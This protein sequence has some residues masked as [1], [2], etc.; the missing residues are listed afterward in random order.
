MAGDRIFHMHEGSTYIEK[1]VNYV[2][3]NLVMGTTMETTEEYPRPSTDLRECIDEVLPLM[4]N[5]SHWFCIYRGMVDHGLNKKKDYSGFVALIENLYPEGVP[6]GINAGDISKLDINSFAKPVKEW[7]G[8]DA[9]RKG[10]TFVQYKKIAE[11]FE[12]LM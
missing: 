4:S 12:S 2:K 10:V 11:M 3:G 8:N 7:D 1:Q 5:A 6:F 9:P